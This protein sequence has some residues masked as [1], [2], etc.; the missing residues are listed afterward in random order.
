MSRG[1]VYIE[2]F[3]CQMNELDS[4]LV[5]GALRAL[6]YHFTDEPE[7]A[8]IVLFNTCSVRDNAEQ[9]VRSRLGELMARKRAEPLLVVGVLGCMAERDGEAMLGRFP[10]V[11]VLCGP[12]EL[13]T[14][15]TLLDNAA[16]TR[17]AML[18]E[19]EG[20]P[21][22]GA[23]LRSAREVALQGSASRRSG[24]LAAASDSLEPSN[25]AP[26]SLM[27]YC[28]ERKALSWATDLK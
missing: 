7:E 13:D 21:A 24:T 14:L 23:A 27:A 11:D 25:R 12:G 2:T 20:G 16:R 4:Q 5:T 22:S 10:V 19:E 17:R 28:K 6:G 9:K 8:S 1:V 18:S 26:P 15:P 3:G